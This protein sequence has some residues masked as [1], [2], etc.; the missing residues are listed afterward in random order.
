MLDPGRVDLTSLKHQGRMVLG[1]LAADQGDGHPAVP[2]LLR[3]D[4]LIVLAHTAAGCSKK[5]IAVQT[6]VRAQG[7]V[8]L[9]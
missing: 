2:D 3:R 8:T 6:L 1:G 9:P 4:V 7:P 5:P